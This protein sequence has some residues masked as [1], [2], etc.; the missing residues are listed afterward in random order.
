MNIVVSPKLNYELQYKCIKF[1]LSVIRK[2]LLAQ[3]Y[4][5]RA[6]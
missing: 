4:A 6:I 5:R 2:F 3:Q 1:I